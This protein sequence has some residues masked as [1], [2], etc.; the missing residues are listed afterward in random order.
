MIIKSLRKSTRSKKL[1]LTVVVI[2]V[3]IS[4]FLILEK[5]GITHIIGLFDNKTTDQAKEA[6]INSNDK[7]DLI[8]S[9][10]DNRNSDDTAP[11][12]T[13]DDIS[14]ST[15]REIDGSVTIFNELRN[16]SDGTCDLTIN[17]DNKTYTQTAPVLYQAEFSSCIGLNVPVATLGTGTWQISLTVTSKGKVNTKTTSVEVQ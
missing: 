4:T 14:L 12:P 15:Q 7:Q 1:L 10:T 5:T 6:E 16:Y 8:D 13:V 3:L 11:E 9:K 2:V 17:N